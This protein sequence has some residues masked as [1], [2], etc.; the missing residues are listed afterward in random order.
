MDPKA[1]TA[2]RQDLMTG[3]RTQEEQ[4]RD[5]QK[6]LKPGNINATLKT[7]ENRIHKESKNRKSPSRT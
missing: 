1:E 7:Q 4:T 2:G 3:D 5:T 6:N